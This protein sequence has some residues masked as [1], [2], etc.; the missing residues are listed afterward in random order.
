MGA[1]IKQIRQSITIISMG[2]L[3]LWLILLGQYVNV[4]PDTCFGVR[5]R[6]ALGLRGIFLSPF[7]HGGFKHL[8]ANTFPL[9]ILGT[10][11]LYFYRSIAL[12][13]WLYIYLASGIWVWALARANTCHIGASGI[14]Y[15]LAFFLFFSGI[16]RK[17]RLS[18]GIALIVSF[19]YGGLIWGVLPAEPGVSWEGHLFGAIAGIMTAYLLRKSGP[20]P[21]RKKYSWDI[22]PENDE[23]N[24]GI[25]NYKKYFPPPEGY[26]HP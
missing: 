19:L 16:F 14:I 26:Q 15:G 1:N 21:P 25:W 9:L 2:I 4:I 11:V 24:K 5:P 13:I 17:D 8:L 7:L 23:D 18:L 3:L 12:R 10:T 6:E 22:E 20:P